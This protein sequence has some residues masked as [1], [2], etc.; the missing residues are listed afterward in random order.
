MLRQGLAIALGAGLLVGMVGHADAA[1]KKRADDGTITL[2][3]CARFWPPFC[4]VLSTGAQSY[5]LIGAVPAVPVNT[6]V[7]VVGVKSGDVSLC[8]G[9]PV[10]VVRWRPNKMR[11]PAM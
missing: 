4:T 5:S 8:F 7:T 11:C 3:G 1:K 9:T 2:S 10:R 6:G